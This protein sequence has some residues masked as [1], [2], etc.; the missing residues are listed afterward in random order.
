MVMCLPYLP[1]D[2]V[3]V[4]SSLEFLVHRYMYIGAEFDCNWYS[5]S[6]SFVFVVVVDK[7]EEANRVQYRKG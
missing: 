2:Q 7:E 3:T 6:A 1:Y 5:S 4:C